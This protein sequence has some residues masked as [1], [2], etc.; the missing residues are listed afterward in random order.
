M[1]TNTSS[2][3]TTT[4]TP[5]DRLA[6]QIRRTRLFLH[7]HAVAAEDRLNE[8]MSS[9]LDLE[10]S[11]TNTIASLAP[12][13]ESGEQLMPGIIYVLVASMAGSIISRNRNL[14][15]RTTV[16]V[17]VGIG[18]GWMLL[19]ITTRNVADLVWRFEQKA[20]VISESHLRIRRAV[21]EAWRRARETGQV[22]LRAIDETVHEG[23]ESVEDWVRKGK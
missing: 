6:H 9:F 7:A 15:V 16:P 23:R 3:P 17:A 20:P 11:F 13:K 1:S 8:L 5:T 18:A 2:Q 12:P 14:L 22:T 19:P 21:G 4:P 10:T